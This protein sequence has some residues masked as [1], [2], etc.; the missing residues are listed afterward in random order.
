[1]ASTK[2]PTIEYSKQSLRN[3]KEIVAYLRLRFTEN[4]VA[5]FYK[6]LDDFEKVISSY[7]GLYPESRKKKIRRAV[8]SR[9]LSVYYL[10]NNNTISIIAIFDNRWD[11]SQKVK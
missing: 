7:P 2:K 5:K 8:L 4:E 10:Y 3:A 11:E 1:M 9:V 6:A